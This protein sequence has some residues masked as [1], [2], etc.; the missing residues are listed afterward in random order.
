MNV[1]SGELKKIKIL[2]VDDHTLFAEGTMSLLAV[3]PSIQVVGIAKTGTDCLAL[4][5]K[6]NPDVVLLDIYLPDILGTDLIDKIKEVR[7]ETKIIMLTGQNPQGFINKAIR[8]GANGFLLKDCSVNEMVDGILKVYYGKMYFSPV[9]GTILESENSIGASFPSTNP[10][11]TEELL[12]LTEKKV[13]SMVAQGLQNK[14]IAALIGIK[15]G[16]VNFHISNILLKFGVETR[17]EALVKWM[18]IEK[19]K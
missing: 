13:M 11:N 19:E 1:S 10:K 14:E 18:N 5:D 15:P 3:E 9:I 2:I 17:L 12:T 8:R 16:T 4:I 6:T 7:A